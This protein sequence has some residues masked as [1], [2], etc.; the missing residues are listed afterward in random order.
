MYMSDCT[1]AMSDCISQMLESHFGTV[2][3]IGIPFWDPNLGFGMGFGIP[4]W[5]PKDGMGFLDP[6]G[7]PY[8]HGSKG[9]GRENA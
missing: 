4:T 8:S 1:F 5:D 3:C 7:F 2:L 6:S 9:T